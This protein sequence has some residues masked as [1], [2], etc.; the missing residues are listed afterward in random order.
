M[1]DLTIDGEID[2]SI[3]M[4]AYRQ[5]ELAG[6]LRVIGVVSILG[7]GNSTTA[8]IHRNLERRLPAL[9]G[10]LWRR[11]RGP[12]ERYTTVLNKRAEKSADIERLRAIAELIKSATEPVVIAELGPVTVSAR[13]LSGGYVS[14]AE[15]E[16]ILAVGGRVRNESFATNRSLGRVFAFRDMNVSEDV[17]AQ[18]FLIRHHPAKLWMVTYRTGIGARAATAPVIAQTIP[19]LAAHAKSRARTLR[20]IGFLGIPTWDTWTTSFFLR[21]GS[22]RL[23]CRSIRARLAITSNSPNS[24]RLLLG[25]GGR[26]ITACTNVAN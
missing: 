4:H 23:G 13:L 6:C 17:W 5:L 18:D 7:N 9:G 1:T 26:T 10:G 25:D 2:D 24:M 16:K 12:D 3:S 15:I 22:S 21:T 19:S 14:P 11:L 20:M 8:Q